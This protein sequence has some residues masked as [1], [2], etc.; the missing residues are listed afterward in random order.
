[1]LSG[2]KH[3]DQVLVDFYEKFSKNRF[4]NIKIKFHPI[5]PSSNFKKNFS[6]EIKGEGSYIIKSSYIVV[7][8]SYTSGLYE[9]ISNNSYTILL[10]SSASDKN[11]FKYLK[12]Y[13]K[14][15]L[16]SSDYEQMNLQIKKINKDS[17][18][19]YKDN[20]ISKNFF[21]NN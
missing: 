10:E 16:L 3:S 9:S 7:T 13:S 11:L 6:N 14:K 12:N 17:N 19:K 4:S 1:M 5:L 18:L 8:T 21:F 15:I 2:I 20:K